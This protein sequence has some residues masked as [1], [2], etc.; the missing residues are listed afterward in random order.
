MSYSGRFGIYYTVDHE[1]AMV[2][3]HYIEDQRMDP[4]T[5]FVHRTRSHGSE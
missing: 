5:R 2:Y 3:I 1:A 4:K